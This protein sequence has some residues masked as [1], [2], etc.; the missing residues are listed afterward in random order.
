MSAK[1]QSEMDTLEE[2]EGKKPGKS[3]NKQGFS[4]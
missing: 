3:E 1:Y 2:E 4:G